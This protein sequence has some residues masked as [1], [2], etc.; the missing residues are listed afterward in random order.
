[1][2]KRLT[3]LPPEYWISSDRVILPEGEF[4]ATLHIKDGILAQVSPRKDVVQSN[5]ALNIQIDSGVIIPGIVDTHV[6]VN[7]PGRTE[8][9]GFVTATRAAAAGGITTLVDMPLNSIPVTTDLKALTLKAQVAAG[10]CSVD[11]GLW[12]GIIPGNA[13][14]LEAMIDAGVLGFKCFLCHSGIDDFPNATEAE[15]R[16]AM[17]ILARRGIPLL[18][19]A[20][21][22]PPDA[23]EDDPRITSRRY[24]DFLESRPGQWEIDAVNLVIRLC[25]ETGCAVHIVHLSCADALMPLKAARDEGLPITV[26]TCPH[27]LFFDAEHI[28]DGATHFKCAPPIRE[29]AN[30]ERLWQGLKDGVID[31]VVCDHSPCTPNLKLMESGDFLHA[32]GGIAS[33]QFAP[34]I[35]WTQARTRGFSVSQLVEWLSA[36]PAR[37]AGLTQKGALIEG[38]DADFVVWHPER[39]YRLEQAMIHHRHPITPYLGQTLYGVVETTYVRGQPVFQQDGSPRGLHRQ[40]PWGQQVRRG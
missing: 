9:E 24:I 1:M 34:S 27:Y 30:R 16:M 22:L 10:Q 19:H 40:E 33:L 21:L 39:S 6:H 3:P 18:V 5:N 17:P 26:E 15:L 11:Y 38:R 7:E 12:G 35:V 28:P 31:F 32:W 14:E 13:A 4:P 25:R 23:P 37:F 20:E 29:S 36:R 2:R 8:W